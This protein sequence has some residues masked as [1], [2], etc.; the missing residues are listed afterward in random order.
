MK[1][2]PHT[3]VIVFAI[4][5]FVAIL[6]WIIPGG[7]FERKTIVVSGHE[8]TVIDAQS[9][10]YTKN[11]PQ[12]V[13]I[14]SAF[15]QGFVNQASIII[16]ILIIGGTFWIINTTKSID[17]GI[18]SIIQH[19]RKLD[20]IRLVKSIGSEQIILSFV[21][22]IFSL[23]GAVFGMSEE[24][25]AFIV[26]FVPL[27]IS[28]GYDSIVGVS[29]TYLAAHVGFASA[30][31]NPFTIGI[32]QGISQIPLF[33]GLEYRF[34]C[35]LVINIIAI[36]FVLFYARKVKK[37]PNISPM[38]TLDNIW[39][40]YSINN[41]SETLIKPTRKHWFILALLSIIGILFSLKYYNTTIAI[42]KSMISLP[43]ILVIT[44]FFIITSIFILRK[45]VQYFI[46][47]LL[48]T[49]IFVLIVGVLGYEW[50]IKELAALFLALGL[51]TAWVYGFSANETVKHFIEGAKDILS[52]ALVVG[53][54]GGIIVV[55]NDGKIID[56]ILYYVSKS[57]DNSGK[58]VSVSMMYLFQNG[59]N[60]IIPSGSAK[61]ALTMPIM[62][63]FS[64][65]IGISRQLTVL[66]FQFG[67]GF[68][69]MITPTS[70]VLLGALSMAKIPYSIWFR[71][72]LPFILILI[73]IG[74]LLLLPPLYWHFN[75]F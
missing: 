67:D 34:F 45:S 36:A 62:S 56:T 14:L 8:R 32:A 44:I 22:I 74:W 24:T 17:L 30:M 35:W 33:S 27:A 19:I 73:L 15:Y 49:T 40:N 70:G 71:W 52:A 16:F 59:L 7:E 23:F 58:F 53:L 25:I 21:M 54:A 65:L 47:N 66:A 5:V 10:K 11:N 46:L 12:T 57:L 28:M 63:Q 55:L 50:Y 31:L 26:I 37:N 72:I 20:N 13:E 9:F 51:I 2:F 3:Y 69:N 6:T 60:I 68:T 18:K 39:K 4:I 64:D 61:A 48:L 29:I 38:A 1:K 75:G 42:G 43:I 41:E